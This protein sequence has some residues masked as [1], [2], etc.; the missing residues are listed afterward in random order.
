MIIYIQKPFELLAIITDDMIAIDFTHIEARVI[1]R[2][3]EDF[4]S[5][6]SKSWTCMHF[7]DTKVMVLVG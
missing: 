4:K 7:Q 3:H 6:F 2:Q 1:K 5:H